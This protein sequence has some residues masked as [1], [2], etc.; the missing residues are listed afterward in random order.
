M[1]KDLSLVS[2]LLSASFFAVR[3]QQRLYF[4]QINIKHEW[5]KISSSWCPSQTQWQIYVCTCAQGRLSF[6][7]LPMPKLF[8]RTF[9]LTSLCVTAAK[10]E[11]WKYKWAGCPCRIRLVKETL[12]AKSDSLL[13]GRRWGWVGS[14]LAALQGCGNATSVSVSYC[15]YCH[16]MQPPSLAGK[17]NLSWKS[18]SQGQWREESS[19]Y[20][21]L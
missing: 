11:S 13:A 17:V 6:Q 5:R 9:M 16:L 12:G 14:L 2:L 18:A 3:L 20:P 7:G 10:N 15:C 4:Q 21:R 1:I 8:G 19:I